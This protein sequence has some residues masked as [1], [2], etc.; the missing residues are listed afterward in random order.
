MDS[1]IDPSP[2]TLTL[3]HILFVCKSLTMLT[4][5]ILKHN[6]LSLVICMVLLP[7]VECHKNA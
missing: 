3:L 7:S 5:K 1:I 6:N 4:V 2:Y